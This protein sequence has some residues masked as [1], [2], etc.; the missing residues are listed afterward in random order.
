M[1]AFTQEKLFER[2]IVQRLRCRGCGS[3]SVELAVDLGSM[4]LA[5]DYLL[6]Q[7]EPI[8]DEHFYPLMIHICN[9]CGLLQN[10]QVIPPERLYKEYRFSSSTVQPLV[11]HFKKY[12]FWLHDRFSPKF[13]VEFGCNDGILLSPLNRLDIK[14]LGVDISENI[15]SIARL[16][17]LMVR[18]GIFDETMADNI[19]HEHGLADIVTGSNVFAHV[20]EPGI[21]LTAARGLLHPN[22][23]FCIEVMYA[24]DLLADL[25]WDSMYHEHLSFYSLNNL[26]KLF[27]RYGFHIIDAERIPMHAGSIRVVASLNE[28]EKPSENV[29]RIKE[30]ENSIGLDKLETWQRFGQAVHTKIKT[31]G[32]VMEQLSKNYRIW[33]YGAAGRASMWLNAC[34]MTYLE[35]IVD[36]SPL[37]AGRLIPGTHTPIVFPTA[38]RSNPPDI[39]LLTA[40][41]Y[42]EKIR[43]QEEWYGGV[44]IVPSPELTFFSRSIQP[45]SNYLG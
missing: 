17:G 9:D 27:D 43:T 22:G 33:A 3:D 29:F 19:R 42:L 7:T 8:G 15:T 25:Q 20:D 31:V 10:M 18:T 34:N 37:R 30:Y 16:N 41:N 39:L 12:A 26:E 36:A 6:P 13:V 28:H 4:P 35:A 38:L 11:D 44:W 23:H 21:V 24:A 40:W 14:S 2:T 32:R 5:G 1:N 45:V